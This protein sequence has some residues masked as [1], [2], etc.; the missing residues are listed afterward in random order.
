VTIALPNLLNQGMKNS[1]KKFGT[2]VPN[3]LKGATGDS[4]V[5]ILE[6]KCLLII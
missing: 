1:L 2:A 5:N 3:L 4:S 6:Y